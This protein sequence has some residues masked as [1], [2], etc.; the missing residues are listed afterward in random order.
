M[1]AIPHAK[2]VL[3]DR[4]VYEAET[5]DRIVM[6]LSACGVAPGRVIFLPPVPEYTFARHMALYDRLDIALDTIPFNSG[7]TAFDALW[8]G[9][10]LVALEGNRVGGRMASSIVRTLGRPEWASRNEEDYVAIV[11]ALASDLEGRKEFRKSQRARMIRS[12]LC[13][14]KGLARSLEAALE[15]M[16]DRWASE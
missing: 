8:M 12:P 15:A 1:N 13:D 3:E 16:Y 14:A 6:T 5:H 9:V 11:A 2:L 7:T 10:P 4:T